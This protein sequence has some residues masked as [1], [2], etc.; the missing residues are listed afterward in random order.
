LTRDVQYRLASKTDADAD[1]FCALSN[2]L[3]ARKVSPAYFNWQFFDNPSDPRLIFMCDGDE[4][5]GA[6]GLHLVGAGADRRAMCLDI[7]IAKSA[8]GRGLI[9][10]FARNAVWHAH[11]AGARSVGVVGNEKARQ[12]LSRHLGWTLVRTIRAHEISAEALPGVSGGT[13]QTL[14]DVPARLPAAAGFYPRNR[15]TLVWRTRLNPRYPYVWLEA[16]EAFAVVKL[17][18][19]PASDRCYG[20]VL[21]IFAEDVSPDTYRRHLL[22]FCG[23][24][25]T[26]GATTLSTIPAKESQARTLEAAGFAPG[27]PSRHVMTPDALSCDFGMLDI[28]VF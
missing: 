1:A 22:I 26:M 24:L 10:G 28:D 9:A 4:V 13:W 11:E 8:Q 19:D 7:M 21:D 25:K 2:S 27:G 20:D 17:F 18:R 14:E 23:A 16:D 15:D 5:I 6:F 12:A 3:Y